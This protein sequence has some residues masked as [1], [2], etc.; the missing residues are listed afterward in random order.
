MGAFIHQNNVLLEVSRM[1]T[2][3]WVKE[4]CYRTLANGVLD[5]N[6]L[7]A[8]FDLFVSNEEAISAEP[9]VSA[10][11]QLR[12]MRLVHQEGV[13]ALKAGSE[14]NFCDEGITLVFGQ[15]GSG[16]SGYYRVLD[17]LAGGTLARSVIENISEAHPASPF[18]RIGYKLDGVEQPLSDWDNTDATKGKAP[19]DKITVFDSKYVS[20]LVKKH[21]PDTY[22]LNTHGF[23]DFADLQVNVSNLTT[24]VRTECPEKETLLNVPDLTILNLD[25]IYD[26]YLSA[27]QAQLTEEIKGL[28][29]KNRGISVAKQIEDGKP[30]LVVKLNAPYDVDNI[31]SEGEIK[32]VALALVLSDLELKEK[33]N[34]LVLDDPV[35]SLDNNIIRRF[36]LR[37]IKLENQVILFTHNIWLTNAL[38]KNNAKVHVYKVNSRP[39]TRTDPLKKH[40]IVYMV[41]RQ[42]KTTGILR[43]YEK[44]NPRYYLACAKECID[45][46]PFGIKEAE[47]ATQLLRKAVELMV[48]EKIFLDLEPC[49]YRYGAQGILWADLQG[50]KSV[51][52]ALNQKLQEQFVIL[53]SG[54]THTG[55]VDEEDSLEHDDLEDVY[56]ELMALL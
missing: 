16:K 47:S 45:V 20:Y 36:A 34:P 27:L 9:G 52:D 24:K 17:H 18:C 5:N 33:K 2:F 11:Q 14:M 50:L 26:R 12:L 3:G 10:E 54:G 37:L 44:D 6:G 23:F 51:P 32:A 42:G 15:N 40:L 13:N 38:Y 25:G 4:L 21:T 43:N 31:L 8:V 30:Y 22:L 56:N 7:Q 28:L 39:E 41:N 53:S 1:T 29:G 55:L 46:V 19:F 48:D 35:N 49:K